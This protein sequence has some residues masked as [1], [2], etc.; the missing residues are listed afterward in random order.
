[1][2][3]GI[4]KLLMIVKVNFS[5]QRSEIRSC[6]NSTF[7]IAR[8]DILSILLQ[9]FSIFWVGYNLYQKWNLSYIRSYFNN[10]IVIIAPH[11]E[12]IESVRSNLSQPPYLV[13]VVKYEGDGSLIIVDATSPYSTNTAAVEYITNIAK[14]ASGLGKSGVT[15]MG[16]MGI[17]T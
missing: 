12:T 4:F 10:E 1:M 17:F 8:P 13:D 6:T 7:H 15:V 9:Q 16:D 5:S 2:I 11:Y 14:D 3:L